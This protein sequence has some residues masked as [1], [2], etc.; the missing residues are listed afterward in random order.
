MI[1]EG[2]RNHIDGLWDITLNQSKP[3]TKHALPSVNAILCLDKTQSELAMFLHAAAGYLTKS[4]FINAINKGYFSTWPGLTTKLIIKY[5]PPSI[6]TIKG[7][8]KQ[9]PKN[10]VL[11]KFYLKSR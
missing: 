11:P 6:P 2:K 4:S 3:P 8:I 9:E 10:Y 1:L 5:L 7:H